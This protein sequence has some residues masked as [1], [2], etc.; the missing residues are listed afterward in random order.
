MKLNFKHHGYKYDITWTKQEIQ[1][2]W[3]IPT[4]IKL[5][6][7]G[8]VIPDYTLVHETP[9]YNIFAEA[10]Y[11][12]LN[13]DKSYKFTEVPET[14]QDLRSKL[15][16]KQATV[17]NRAVPKNFYIDIECPLPLRLLSDDGAIY[18]DGDDYALVDK[19]G[20]R[21]AT[22]EEFVMTSMIQMYKNNKI[23]YIDDETQKYIDNELKYPDYEEEFGVNSNDENSIDITE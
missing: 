16:E 17:N 19:N 18:A 4:D 14:I 3:V 12:Y 23:L 20:S 22:A 13:N 15:F 2:G 11:G 7:N 8:K 21:I 6:I 1:N 5:A 9:K 10:I